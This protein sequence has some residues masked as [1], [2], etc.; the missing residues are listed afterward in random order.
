[1]DGVPWWTSAAIVWHAGQTGCSIL[2]K[3]GGARCTDS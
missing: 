3:M 2:S 1:M